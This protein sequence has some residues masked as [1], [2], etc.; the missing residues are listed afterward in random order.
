MQKKNKQ[1]RKGD[2]IPRLLDDFN[3]VYKADEPHKS[4]RCAIGHAYYHAVKFLL[5]CGLDPNHI[6]EDRYQEMSLHLLSLEDITDKTVRICKLLLKHGARPNIKNKEGVTA[7]QAMKKL[8]KGPHGFTPPCHPMTIKDDQ[9]VP[10]EFTKRELQVG[11]RR[12]RKMVAM[13]EESLKKVNK[14]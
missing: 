1:A 13:M 3:H 12:V 4:L 2:D 6:S 14:G 11:E 5:E 10:Y 7:L 8:L 9:L